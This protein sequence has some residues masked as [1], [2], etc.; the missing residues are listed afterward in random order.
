M[1]NYPIHIFDYTKYFKKNG[2]STVA[3][4]PHTIGLRLDCYRQIKSDEE[5]N[6]LAPKEITS[7]KSFTDAFYTII[8]ESLN[9]QTLTQDDWDR[10]IDINT[11]NISPKIR[12]M[13]EAEKN[14]LINSGKKGVQDYFS[15]K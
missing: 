6:G 1:A 13:S 3:V 5:G 7:F 2:D 11:F 9:R 10:T 14:K 8:I 4:N 15:K 12:Q